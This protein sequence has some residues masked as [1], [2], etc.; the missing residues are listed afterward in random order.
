MQEFLRVNK[1]N[2][3]AHAIM[4]WEPLDRVQQPH[5]ILAG[6]RL[7]AWALLIPTKQI[8][9]DFDVTSYSKRRSK[10]TVQLY[11]RRVCRRRGLGSALMDEALK[12]DPRPFCW[13]HDKAS[14]TFFGAYSVT[15][16]KLGRNTYIRKYESESKK[17]KVLSSP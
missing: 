17:P 12:Y 4:I 2:Q 6:K 14:G 3:D 9:A 5:P 13:P 7:S 8:S 10:Y 16:D 1:A 11:V 15:T